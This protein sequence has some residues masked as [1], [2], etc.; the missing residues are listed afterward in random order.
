MIIRVRRYLRTNMSSWNSEIVIIPYRIK[1]DDLVFPKGGWED[2]ETIGEAACRE[3]LEE[4][5][6]KGILD[7]SPLGMWEFRSKGRQ[8]S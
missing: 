1:K 4:A 6:V 8:N 2:D 5:S 7:E 3:A